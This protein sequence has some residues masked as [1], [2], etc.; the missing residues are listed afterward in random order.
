MQTAESETAVSTPSPVNY[1]GSPICEVTLDDTDYRFDAGKQGTAVS[2]SKRP[3][4][5]WDWTFCGEARWD[6]S[7]LRS[8]AFDRSVLVPLSAAFKRALAELES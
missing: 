4:G 7:D 5:T 2:L 3:S 1:E 6:G 8:K